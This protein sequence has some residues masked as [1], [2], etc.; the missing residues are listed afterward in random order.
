[1]STL[2]LRYAVS[3][4]LALASATLSKV[5]T[6]VLDMLRAVISVFLRRTMIC[7]MRRRSSGTRIQS[8]A[9]CVTSNSSRADKNLSST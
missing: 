6:V 7:L 9:G 4:M 1:M 3:L 5:I 8:S 2:L